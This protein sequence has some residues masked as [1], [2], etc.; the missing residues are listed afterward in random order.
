MQLMSSFV[1]FVVNVIVIIHLSPFQLLEKRTLKKFYFLSVYYI[2]K[3]IICQ[4]A[5]TSFNKK[6]VPIFFSLAGNILYNFAKNNDF[7]IEIGKF[8]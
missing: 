7:D 3:S 1:K 8:W 4:Y 5:F 2:I 6:F